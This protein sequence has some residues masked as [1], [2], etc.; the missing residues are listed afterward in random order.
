M[1]EGAQA[2]SSSFLRQFFSMLM[3]LAISRSPYTIIMVI[4]VSMIWGVGARIAY[5]TFKFSWNLFGFGA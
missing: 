2:P 1:E 5:E 3:A 4:V